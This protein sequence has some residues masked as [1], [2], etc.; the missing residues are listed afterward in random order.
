MQ[1]HILEYIQSQ[2]HMPEG[3]HI[4][5]LVRAIASPN[6]NI[7]DQFT[8]EQIL[9]TEIV[10]SPQIFRPALENLVEVGLLYTTVDDS[11]FLITA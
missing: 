3:V 2:P 10:I 9:M 4:S 8:Y 5:Q 7:A 11:H 1:R 6:I